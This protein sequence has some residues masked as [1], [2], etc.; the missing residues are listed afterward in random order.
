MNGSPR[1]TSLE[2][3][4]V[5]YLEIEGVDAALLVSTDGLLVS[6]AGGAGRDLDALAARTA[7]LVA[8]AGDLSE[9]L[10][11]RIRL[12]ALDNDG[13]AV[14]L[15]PLTAELQL[16]IMGDGSILRLIRR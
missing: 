7:A 1:A 16:M 6:R 5:P 12:L 14:I 9:E 3:L 10:G 4:L 2:R 15:A 13:E 8:S 11:N